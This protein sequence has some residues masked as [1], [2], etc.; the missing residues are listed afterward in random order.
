MRRIPYSPNVN[1]QVTLKPRACTS[2]SDRIVRHEMQKGL[3][4]NARGGLNHQLTSVRIEIPKNK[5]SDGHVS[6]DLL[7]EPARQ[8]G[9]LKYHTLLL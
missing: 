1:G 6:R 5:G 2:T 9:I 7:S 8:S 4:K 3:V